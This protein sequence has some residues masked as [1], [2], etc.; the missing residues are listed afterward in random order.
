MV[1]QQLALG[2]VV[3]YDS[4]RVYVVGQA[5]AEAGARVFRWTGKWDNY[6]VRFRAGMSAAVRGEVPEIVTV[7]AWGDR[8]FQ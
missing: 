3:V 6:A 1:T 7:S 2:R 5:Q 8:A 4:G